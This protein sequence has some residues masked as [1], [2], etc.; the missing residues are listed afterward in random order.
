MDKNGKE[1]DTYYKLSDTLSTL[2]FLKHRKKYFFSSIINCSL[3][4]QQAKAVFSLKTKYLKNPT[5]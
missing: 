2:C 3:I 5:Q 1:E 4:F